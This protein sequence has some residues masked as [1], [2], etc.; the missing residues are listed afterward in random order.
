MT[1]QVSSLAIPLLS[2]APYECI[3]GLVVTSTVLVIEALT[4]GKL[5]LATNASNAGVSV[6]LA[7]RGSNILRTGTSR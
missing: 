4:Q 5:N 7:R 1:S 6:R 2:F 3:A